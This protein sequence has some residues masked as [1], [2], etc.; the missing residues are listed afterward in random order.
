MR[1]FAQ[2][3]DRRIEA[4]SALTPA[5]FDVGDWQCAPKARIIMEEDSTRRVVD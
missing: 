5:T 2:S 1:T 4:Y 3:A